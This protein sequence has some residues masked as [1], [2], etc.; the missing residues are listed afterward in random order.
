MSSGFAVIDNVSVQIIR[1]NIKSLR[2]SI[3]PPIGNVKISAPFF[4]SDDL[5]ISAVCKKINWIKKHRERIINLPLKYEPI[6]NCGEQHY[7]LGKA[8]TL[9]INYSSKRDIYFKDDQIIVSIKTDDDNVRIQK[10]LNVF[11]ADELKKILPDLISKWSL[12]IGKKPDEFRIKNMKTRW[13]SCNIRAK[14]IWFNSN[15]AKKN[16]ECIEYVVVH[17]LVHFLEKGH[18]SLFYSYMDKFL[19]NWRD[20]KFTLNSC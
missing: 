19:P 17:E 5:I 12:I 7:F 20:R 3:H 4:L 9:K 18:N 13:G 15:L 14:R 11:Y 8:F 10:L 1:K 6:Y 16:P 2:I